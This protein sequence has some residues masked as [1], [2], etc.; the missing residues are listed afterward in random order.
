MSLPYSDFRPLL[1]KHTQSQLQ[2]FATHGLVISCMRFIRRLVVVVISQFN[3]TPTPKGSYSA[4]TGDDDCN[5]NSSRYSL[6][7]ALCESIRYQAK[8]EQNVRQDLTPRERHVE[9]AL[10]NPHPKI[11]LR[12]SSLQ[13]SRKDQVIL[14][15]CRIRHSR[16]T[17]PFLLN[18]EPVPECVCCAC[19]NSACSFRMCRPN[20]IETAIF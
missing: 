4:K 2:L 12:K 8:S 17:H 14:T 10:M 1:C 5:V 16:L 6:R 19:D 11:G 3:G 13:L 15:R 9:A 7:N 18:N 20:F